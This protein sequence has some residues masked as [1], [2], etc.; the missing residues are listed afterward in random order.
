MGLRSTLPAPPRTSAF[1]G[2]DHSGRTLG[3]VSTDPLNLAST[4][5]I[6]SQP[7]GPNQVAVVPRQ[8]MDPLVAVTARQTDELLLGPPWDVP[9]RFG[10]G[11]MPDG[12]S[13][14][15]GYIYTANFGTDNVSIFDRNTLEWAQTLAVG[16]EPSLF[17][18]DPATGDV[19]LS[20]HG[21]NKIAPAAR[22]VHR[23]RVQRY[24][25]AL[26]SGARPRQPP[27]IRGEPGRHPHG[28]RAR[29]DHGP[30]GRRHRHRRGTLC[31]G[32]ESRHRPSV[33][34]L[35][36]PRERVSH[37]GLVPRHYNPSATRR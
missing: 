3:L 34:R 31:A 32:R 5:V 36:R 15:G 33:R 28:D 20:L 7:A 6:S 13:V 9:R 23:E 8:G 4:V 30:R 11:D 12:V 26:R 24:S 17:A 18:A 16:H 29:P 22:P 1:H 25:G 10:V 35:R 19:Y 14:A 27:A 2:V 21:A 37:R